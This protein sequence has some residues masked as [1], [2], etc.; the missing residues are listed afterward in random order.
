MRYD[1]IEK[2]VWDEWAAENGATQLRGNPV[3]VVAQNLVCSSKING[4]EAHR[5][6]AGFHSLL[7]AAARRLEIFRDWGYRSWDASV[8]LLII[9]ITAAVAR[10][11][12]RSLA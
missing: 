6:G 4:W 8:Y 9:P 12:V 10:T 11:A 2:I 1:G 3:L 5:R 7:C